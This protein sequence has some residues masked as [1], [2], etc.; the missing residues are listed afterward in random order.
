MTLLTTNLRLR[1]SFPRA[2]RGS[3]RACRDD[4]PDAAARDR[5]HLRAIARRTLVVLAAVVSAAPPR[6]AA[7][8]EP[9]GSRTTVSGDTAARLGPGGVVVFA[10]AVRRW[11]VEDGE[12]VLLRGRYLELG[13]AVGV[14]PAYLQAGP[15]VEWVPVALLQL[16][17]QY[18]L[19]GFFGAN[20]ALLR[21]PSAASR[22]GDGEIKAAG[23]TETTGLGHRLL[24]SPVLRARI[25]RVVLRSQTDLAW[26]ALSSTAGWFYE[27]EYDTLVA[28]RG[29]VVSNRTALL[30]E[31]WHGPGEAT[32]LVGPGYEITHSTTA[33]ITRQ[34]A[35]GVVF[36]SPVETFGRF[37]RPRIFL[38]AGVNLADRNRGH[39]PFAVL[40]VGID[41]DR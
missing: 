9:G 20:G 22:F 39:D 14:N 18:D 25:G 3:A 33:D 37:A 23:G 10:G 34:R 21:F 13:G 19:Y 30:F 1:S 17:A 32:L 27:W 4:V 5:R 8:T 15:H 31:L 35:E 24:I 26:F 38:L 2:R 28:R 11:A 41:L 6:A 12:G 16:R 40:G 29:L 7:G 36:W